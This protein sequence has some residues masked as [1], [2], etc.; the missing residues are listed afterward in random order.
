MLALIAFVIAFV[1]WLK[2]RDVSSR[3]DHMELERRDL[4]TKVTGLERLV[5]R[6]R[7]Q[8]GAAAA[9]PPPSS[10][11]VGPAPSSSTPPSPVVESVSKPATTSV[12]TA[13]APEVLGAPSPSAAGQIASAGPPASPPPSVTPPGPKPPVAP[14]PAPAPKRE[15]IEPPT[16]PVDWES[17]VGTKATAWVGGIALIAA[18]IFFARWTVEQGLITPAARFALMLLTGVGA[19]VA[20]ELGLRRGYERTA[21]PLSGAGIAVLYAAFY[22]GH[23]RYE[24]FSMPIAFAGMVLVTI[25][26]CVVAVR[27]DAFPTAVLGLLGGFATPVALSTG[28]D[29]PVGLFSY[30]LLLNIGLLAVGIRQRW[31]GLFE[32]GLL[33]TLLI[34]IGWFADFMSPANMVV[35]VAVFTIFGL[36]YLVLPVVSKETDNDRVLL[37][38]AFGGVMPFLFALVL[39]GSPQYIPQWPLLFSMVALV[40]LA[41]LVMAIA[42]G[43]VGLLLSA[44]TATAITLGLWAFQGLHP[45][46]DVSVIGPTVFAVLLTTIFAVG[47]RAADRF[48]KLDTALFRPIEVAAIL[49]WAGLAWFALAMLGHQRVQPP[50]AFLTIAAALLVLL[51]ERTSH[52]ARIDGVLAVGSF[53]LASLIQIWFFSA[54]SEPTVVNYLLVPLGLSVAFSSF[55]TW[56][57][58]RLALDAEAEVAVR[59]SAWISIFGLFMCLVQRD[60]AREG[61]PLFGSFAAYVAIVTLSVLRSDWTIG[62]P[63]LLG[64]TAMHL[65]VWQ[66]AYLDESRHTMVFAFNLLFY[67]FF[68]LLPM[69]VPFARWRTAVLPW[70]TSALSGP[71]YFLPLYHVYDEAFGKSTIGLLPVAMAAVSVGALRVVS[72]R[73][74]DSTADPLSARLRLRYLALFSAVALWF[75]AVAIP[76]Q[77]DR[78]WITLGWAIE[79]MALCWLY[80]RLPHRGL[81]T[82]AGILYALVAIRLLINP[83]I[84]EYEP[85]GTPV[86]NWILYTYGVATACCLIGQKLLRRGSPDVFLTQLANSI[87]FAGILLGFWL[88]NLE[89]LDYFSPGP[90]IAISHGGGYSVKLAL[91]AGWAFYSM[92]LLIAGV[93]LDV[94]AVRYLSLAFLLLTVAKVFLYDLSELGGIFRVFSFLGLAIALILVSVFYQ[95]FVFRKTP[96]G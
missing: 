66:V 82:F 69:A 87:A 59:L 78:Q 14:T 30:I 33:G 27:Y 28:V 10:P 62:L 88:V 20:A 58:A 83:E 23:V 76:V 44:A 5:E 64:A 24:L 57:R 96:R 38:G 31:H 40:D 29:R 90:F 81:P 13:R 47:R 16:A 80:G 25:A 9:A 85:H 55:A 71:V 84:L 93:A 79:A 56:R 48:G 2:S 3:L 6:L 94:K 91:S 41:I 54:V 70:L 89:I 4:V 26:A 34:Q 32:L 72:A 65:L 21:N 75:V 37:T 92:V 50:D 19:L 77:F 35:G 51:I 7:N 11:G 45:R 73:F 15:P 61:W 49:S 17:L 46:H 12:A 36:L 8:A 52:D 39:A 60:T 95:R 86:F 68:L 74:T 43:R 67:Y 42:R 18:A 53:V 22:A 63:A 1:A